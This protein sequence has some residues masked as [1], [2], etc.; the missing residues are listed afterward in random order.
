MQRTVLVFNILLNQIVEDD[1]YFIRV[2]IGTLKVLFCLL[3][4]DVNG[5]ILRMLEEI[6]YVRFHNIIL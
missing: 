1:I 3:D 4:N 2:H 5:E 6:V